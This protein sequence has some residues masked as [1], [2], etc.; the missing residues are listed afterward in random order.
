MLSSAMWR[1]VVA[2]TKRIDY[3]AHGWVVDDSGGEHAAE[4]AVHHVIDA[5]HGD[6]PGGDRL[7]ELYAEEVFARHLLIEPGVG[8]FD[9]AVG[10]LPVGEHPALEVEVFLEHLIEQ[11][12]V[13]AG[14][15]AIDLVVGAHHA[16]GLRHLDCDLECKQIGLAHGALVHHHVDDVASGLLIVEGVMFDVAHNV[17]GLH[18][19]CK[20]SDDV[21]GQDRV[22]AGI[23][24]VATVPRLARKVHAAADGHVETHG[25][26][27]PA[28]HLAVEMRGVEIEGAGQRHHGRQQ[29]CVVPIERRHS[30]ADCGVRQIDVRN[31]EPRDPWHVSGA[32][33]RCCRDGTSSFQYTPA[34]AVDELELLRRRHLVHHQIGT[35]I[36]RQRLVVPC[37]VARRRHGCSLCNGG[38]GHGK[39][40]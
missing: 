10:R 22:F 4:N 5:G 27:F 25:T 21:A 31:A 13:L 15:V 6:L 23:L 12:V 40:Y 35:R 8:S 24:E 16:G 33:I 29:R 14:P 2:A 3:A 37:S 32:V 17:L 20:L 38:C 18:S 1:A 9:G 36:R 19:A 7:L 34:G 30:N 11:V 39:D 28:Q 26:Q